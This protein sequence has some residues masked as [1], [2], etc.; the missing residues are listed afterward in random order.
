MVLLCF[1]QFGGGGG[2][3]FP[4]GTGGGYSTALTPSPPSCSAGSLRKPGGGVTAEGWGHRGPD[5]VGSVNPRKSL[6][7]PFGDLSGSSCSRSRDG[8]G[9]EGF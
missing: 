4:L 9:E 8:R 7:G 1:R 5:D 2:K 6:R 3:G